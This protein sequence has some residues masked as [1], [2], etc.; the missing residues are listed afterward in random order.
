MIGQVEVFGWFSSGT[1]RRSPR[2]AASASAQ[3]A[4]CFHGNDLDPF[5]QQVG[6]DKICHAFDVQVSRRHLYDFAVVE[7][8]IRWE[9]PSLSI[10][11]QDVCPPSDNP[12]GFVSEV[13]PTL[14]AATNQGAPK[15]ALPA[16][17][18]ARDSAGYKVLEQ[19]RDATRVGGCSAECRYSDSRTMSL[20]PAPPC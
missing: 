2:R 18:T 20:R 17:R 4:S 8:G 3:I 5:G 15:P 12:V 11:A 6:V 9:R 1:C 16:Y 7:V 14:A 10:R 19:F 13:N